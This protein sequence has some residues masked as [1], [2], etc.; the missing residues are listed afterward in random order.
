MIATYPPNSPSV[1]VSNRLPFAP[2]TS[3]MMPPSYSTIVSPNST[4]ALQPSSQHSK[5]KTILIS[6][7]EPENVN[8]NKQFKRQIDSES[9]RNVLKRCRSNSIHIQS[10]SSAPTGESA[11]LDVISTYFQSIFST[12]GD[13]D[14]AIDSILDWDLTAVNANFGQADVDR[15][16]SIPLSLFPTDDA[17]IWNGTNSGNYTVKAK[18]VWRL[19]HLTL[20]FKLPAMS[21]TEEF[22]LYASAHTSTFEFE[23]FLTLCWSIWFERNAEY[24]GKLPKSPAA[25]LAFATAYLD[26]YQSIHATPSIVSSATAPT[27]T[28]AG[29]EI[30][31][32]K[33][34]KERGG[35]EE[36][37]K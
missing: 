24:H 2:I 11:L 4:A 15:I 20:D 14:N 34:K 37:E 29:A 16:L 36:R 7:D 8:P 3:P 35:E 5:G 13:D 22:L 19:S 33:R 31:A 28:P 1:Q 18:E 10:A 9:L 23:Q 6:E 12:Q 32:R 30:C 21:T 27:A 26:K 17:L 25:I